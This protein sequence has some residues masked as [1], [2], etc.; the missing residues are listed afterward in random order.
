MTDSEM[1]KMQQ[2]AV[3]RAREMQSRAR[4]SENNQYHSISGSGGTNSQSVFRTRAHN[5]GTETEMND[6]NRVPQ[7]NNNTVSDEYIGNIRSDTVSNSPG[8]IIESLLK[9]KDRTIILSLILLLMDEK[10]DNS[11]LLAL[12]YL[13]I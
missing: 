4:G 8:G 5:T 3:R 13:L 12:M 7:E 2:E 11:L 6:E 10:T 1:K 9:D